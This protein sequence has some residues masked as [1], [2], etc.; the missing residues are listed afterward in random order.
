M[1]EIRGFAA[2]PRSSTATDS[3]VGDEHN[4]GSPASFVIPLR[5]VRLELIQL[6]FPA[7]GL[8]G[9]F[10]DTRRRS[11]PHASRNPSGVS[12]PLSACPGSCCSG[13]PAAPGAAG[14]A[15]AMLIRPL[16]DLPPS[17]AAACGQVDRRRRAYE[18]DQRAG[19]ADPL[20]GGGSDRQLVRA[21]L[22]FAGTGCSAHWPAQTVDLQRVGAGPSARG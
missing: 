2:R 14:D 8:A 5:R 11:R 9:Q 3:V 20:H 18:H 17:G 21:A 7:G 10:R 13:V 22:V 19:T 16:A 6:R 4:S 1:R 15:E 12:G